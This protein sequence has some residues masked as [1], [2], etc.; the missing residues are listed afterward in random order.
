M[1]YALS[2]DMG[3]FFQIHSSA[4][5]THIFGSARLMLLCVIYTG[6]QTLKSLGN[7][8]QYRMLQSVSLAK[9]LTTSTRFSV[10]PPHWPGSCTTSITEIRIKLQRCIFYKTSLLRNSPLIFSIS[11][12]PLVLI[13]SIQDRQEVYSVFQSYV[14]EYFQKHI[15]VENMATT[16]ADSA[17]VS[18]IVL[19]NW[20][21]FFWMLCKIFFPQKITYA[22]STKV[23]VW[24]WRT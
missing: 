18:I 2:E 20:L 7:G 9:Y 14:E 19:C 1:I 3:H 8:K 23:K 12:N 4:T 15:Q 6:Q 22:L 21:P 24:L 10:A 17:L 5:S 16:Y 11:Q 13:T